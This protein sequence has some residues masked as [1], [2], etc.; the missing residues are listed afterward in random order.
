MADL[1]R[2]KTPDHGMIKCGSNVF[3]GWF[4]KPFSKINL[5]AVLKDTHPFLSLIASMREKR[6]VYFNAASKTHMISGAII[7]VGYYNEFFLYVYNRSE[8]HMI[9]F[10]RSSILPHVVKVADSSTV[11]ISNYKIGD[12]EIS[13]GMNGTKVCITVDVKNDNYALKGSLELEQYGEPLINVRDTSPGRMIYTHQNPLLKASGNLELTHKFSTGEPIVFD[14][15]TSMGALDFT[16]GYHPANTGWYWIS[17]YGVNIKTNE[18]V[19]INLV[20][21]IDTVSAESTNNI[22]TYWVNGKIYRLETPINFSIINADRGTMGWGITNNS[23]DLSFAPHA[24]RSK[25]FYV[26]PLGSGDNQFVGDC[27]G[28]IFHN[29]AWMYVKLFGVFEEH[30]SVW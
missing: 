23:I 29:E 16:I 4:D 18:S 14:P 9:E 13:I 1:K 28:R 2:Q 30:K 25:H 12:D 26:G 8:R 5:D 15:K 24:T 11:G 19:A 27:V 10:G 7:D 20:R 17:A 3:K 21:D 22:W 6:W